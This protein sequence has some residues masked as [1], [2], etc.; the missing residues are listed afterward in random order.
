MSPT[1]SGQKLQF[2]I[3]LDSETADRVEELVPKLS[4]PGQPATMTDVLRMAVAEGL[5]V[6]EK[7]RK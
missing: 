3:R 5:P 7:R 4:R 1:K 2:T 6:L